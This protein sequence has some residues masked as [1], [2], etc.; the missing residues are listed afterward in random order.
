MHIS[1]QEILLVL[2]LVFLLFGAKRIPDIARSLGRAV[3]EFRKGI[4]EVKDREGDR[5][6]GAGAHDADRRSVGPEDAGRGDDA[7]DDAP[8]RPS[9]GA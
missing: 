2:V 4:D 7:D 1:W 3:R 6:E 8:E 5:D 9:N